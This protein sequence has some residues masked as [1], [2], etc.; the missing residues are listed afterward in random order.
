MK[1]LP[2]NHMPLI[3]R[4]H[5]T[6]ETINTMRV[7][8]KVNRVVGIV[9][10]GNGP[11][12]P[13][14]SLCDI[15]PVG[16]SK[17]V[18]A[19]VVGFQKNSILLMPIGS[20]KGIGPGSKIAALSSKPSI[21]VGM[22]LLGRV[23]DGLGNPI[24]NKGP[25]ETKIEYPVYA[26]PIN[27]LQR[28]MITEPLDVGIKTVNTLI[29]CGKG[30]R[31]GIFA[32][33]GVGKSILLGM[34]ARNTRADVNVIALIGERG[35]E[36]R[37]FIEKD[38]GQEGLERSVVIAA[39]SDQPPLI[40]LRGA[41]IATSIAEYFRDK[42]M[43]VMLMMD[44]LTR[45]AMAQ[46]EVGLAIGEPPTTKGYTPSVF[47]LLPQLLERAGAVSNKGSIT[48]LYSVLIE[49]DDMNDPI[50]D[51]VRSIIDGH[52]A[53]SRDLAAQ[54]HYPAID[55]LQSISRSMIHIVTKE[56]I[57]NAR[58][59]IETLDTYKK[60]EDLIKIGAYVKGSSKKID[61]AVSMID[62]INN[63]LK[64]DIE[65]KVTFKESASQLAAILGS[66]T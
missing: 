48:G 31:L 29:T 9:I 53:L 5:S 42:G 3:A 30:Q 58:K 59:I 39:T 37:E 25:L 24:D 22:Q 44:S 47:S 18:R 55:V 46:R 17:A 41:F 61:Y 54:G 13:V 23:V 62:K 57:Q 49:A 2:E 32:G 11:G 26:D 66:K 56:H 12:V 63:F 4:C 40:R 15:F 10:E 19:E 34:I 21:K 20:I 50:A 36:V 64:Q 60:A 6:V 65:E 27:P 35:R 8:G 7:N 38:L 16:S 14:G 1:P 52:I 28:A 33:S 45:F 43:D 51:S